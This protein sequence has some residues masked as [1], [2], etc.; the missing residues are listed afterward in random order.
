MTSFNLVTSLKALSPNTVTLG[1][2]A[3]LYEFGVG[4]EHTIQSITE[5]KEYAVI[6]PEET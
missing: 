4:W 3:S 2:R 5:T 6:R 1:V